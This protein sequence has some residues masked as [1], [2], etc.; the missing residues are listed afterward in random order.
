MG[1]F[2]ENHRGKIAI[3]H[4]NEFMGIKRQGYRENKREI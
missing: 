4:A 3:N 1:D 2:A